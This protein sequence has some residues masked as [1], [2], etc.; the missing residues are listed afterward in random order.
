MITRRRAAAAPRRR[1]ANMALLSWYLRLTLLAST[2]AA[3]PRQGLLLTLLAASTT[4]CRYE[5]ATTYRAN[6]MFFTE[7]YMYASDEGP[8]PF[9]G[10]D[11]YVLADLRAKLSMKGARANV[12]VMAFSTD[13]ELDSIDSIDLCL[14]NINTVSPRE[15]RK[16]FA[17]TGDHPS[18]LYLKYSVHTAG[19]QYLALQVC[20]GGWLSGMELQGVFEFKN[21]YG[22]VPGRYFGFLP[23]EGARCIFFAL[24]VLYYLCVL[25]AHSGRLLPLHFLTFIVLLVCVAESAAAFAGYLEQNRT[26]QPQCCPFPRIVVASMVLE[27]LR[28]GATRVLLLVVSLGYGLASGFIWLAIL[29]WG[30]IEVAS[31]RLVVPQC[32]AVLAGGEVEE[33]GRV[34]AHRAVL[35]DHER[36]GRDVDDRDGRGREVEQH[37]REARAREVALARRRHLSGRLPGSHR[38]SE[39]NLP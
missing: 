33:H 23:F 28:R 27:L 24:F 34:R 35:E 14:G 39:P 36:V 30:P 5:E 3:L 2:T 37:E 15:K 11:S 7:Y 21:P 16:T 22:F 17:V 31:K 13:E 8:F 32:D 20:D 29:L 12:T 9:S 25:C 6:K 10:G 26:G 4:A 18:H 38:R 1:E 19:L